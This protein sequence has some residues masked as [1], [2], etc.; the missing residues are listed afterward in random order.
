[1]SR[2][3]RMALGRAALWAA[4]LLAVGASPAAAFT[5]VTFTNSFGQP[6]Q[7]FWPP[8]A[9]P[10]PFV[11]NSTGTADIPGTTEL[12]ALRNAFQTHQDISTS[13]AAFLD[14]G[15]NA[16]TVLGNDGINRMV[17]VTND[18][19]MHGTSI[20]ALSMNTFNT[21]DGRILDGDIKYNED[22]TFDA[23]GS[24]PGGTI[25]LQAVATHET[26]HMLGLDHSFLADAT[27]YP[28]YAFAQRSLEQDDIAGIS[29]IYP[30]P[31]F[32]A[33][34]G[35]LRGSVRTYITDRPLM[36]V[37]VVALTALGQAP[38]ATTVT[39][40]NGAYTIPGLPP[41]SYYARIEPVNPANL[42]PYFQ[43]AYT[44]FDPLYYDGVASILQ[45]QTVTVP[46]G[47]ERTGVDF[48]LPDKLPIARYDGSTELTVFLTQ[49]AGANDWF[50]VRLDEN[51]LPQSFELDSFTFVNGNSAA[52]GYRLLVT[53]DSA[54]EPDLASPFVDITGVSAT[55]GQTKVVAL[56]NVEVSQRQDVWLVVKYSPGQP[57]ALGADNDGTDSNPPFGLTGDSYASGDGSNWQVLEI[58]GSP[59]NLG[60][61]LTVV[62]ITPPP[63]PVVTNLSPPTIS[64]GQSG[65]FTLGGQNFLNGVDVTLSGVGVTLNSVT[66]QSAT[67]VQLSLTAAADAPTGLRDL[68]VDN[69]D[70]TSALA[71]SLLT[72]LPAV[73]TTEILAVQNTGVLQSGASNVLVGIQLTNA[74]PVGGFSFRLGYNPTRM[75]PVLTTAPQISVSSTARTAGFEVLGATLLSPGTLVCTGI[76]DLFGGNQQTA[77]AAGAG[78]VI[79][80]AF[81]VPP[82]DT[83]QNFPITLTAANVSDATGATLILP[84]QQSGELQ[85]RVWILGDINLDSLPYTIADALTSVSGLLGTTTLTSNQLL[86]SDVNDDGVQGH[87]S[88]TVFLVNV[89][90]GTQQPLAKLVPAAVAPV[91]M[92]AIAEADGATRIDVDASTPLGGLALTLE[93]PAGATVQRVGAPEAG[94]ASLPLRWHQSGSRLS[95]VLAGFAGER[96]AAGTQTVAWIHS[97]GGQVR[98]TGAEASDP[99]G[100]IVPV[101]TD[102]AAAPRRVFLSEPV[103]NPFNPAT[104][105]A[106]ELPAAGQARLALLDPRGREVAVLH[107][108]P[109]PA[110]AHQQVWRGVDGAGRPVASGVYYA[111]LQAQGVR[112]VRKLAL[113][114]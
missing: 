68:T 79:K 100:R 96:L 32:Y 102:G 20:I 63:Q 97:A 42:G 43:D 44:D 49:P 6:V 74:V 13:T 9:F 94:D 41:G 98:L 53:P 46:A 39:D 75:N 2:P 31:S 27:M 36:G 105:L 80:L 106:F 110:G 8:E 95:V 61:T 11:L 83:L 37:Q 92:R 60:L 72:V 33:A 112:Q 103:P 5:R 29:S 7:A 107:D 24:P 14:N 57:A 48:L 109:L 90:L 19:D 4:V 52:T 73:S 30:D 38:V 62:P 78:T 81:A 64:R 108:G 18:P 51:L 84:T 17:F 56:G 50:A 82:E 67:S 16:S 86:A 99:Q 25:D 23:S 55:A 12:T 66:W 28:F 71:R 104:T 58:S 76:A 40:E 88:D 59:V 89:L 91:R 114:R 15:T 101:Q 77:L 65:T 45:A 113:V 54:G 34:T 93:A 47:G 87:V 10:I 70:G 85:V 22:F 35:R 1:M 3:N 69:P 21:V 26:G 111:V